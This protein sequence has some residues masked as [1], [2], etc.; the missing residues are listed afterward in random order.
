MPIVASGEI[1]LGGNATATRSVACEIQRSGTATIC[2][3]ESAV[4]ILAELPSGQISMSSFYGKSNAPTA[5]GAFFRGGYYTGV[6]YND[7]NAYHLIV[8]PN[9]TGCACCQWKTTYTLTGNCSNDTCNLNNGYWNTFTYLNNA[10]HPAGNWTATRS[11]GGFSDWYLPART[12]LN[13]LY[14]N[15]G[16]MPAGEGY[17]T[18]VISGGGYW[19]SSEGYPANC[20]SYYQGMGSGAFYSIL[21][22]LTS[23][24]RAVRR[25]CFTPSA[26]TAL[27]QF[28]FGGYYTGIITSP[29]NYYLIVAP[30]A[31]GCA[32]CAWKT[33]QTL[34]NNCSNATCNCNNGYWNTFTYLNN[35][36]HPAGNWTATRSI[37]GFSDWYLPARSELN[38]LYTNRGSMPAGEGFASHRYWSSSEGN[39]NG[40]YYQDFYNV[41]GGNFKVYP[42]RLRAVRRVS[43]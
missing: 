41:I 28:V 27:G 30:N 22:L 31:T 42:Y 8:A 3:N 24:L 15:Q 17:N 25:N 5:M 20:F 2:M 43:F 36:A 6:A 19:V 7:C 13:V 37:G 21:K 16:S 11:I 32:C 39:A 29:A 34:T 9:A 10:G 14:T 35:A 38:V 33:T 18:A 4:R 26:P 1:S 12:E 23:R 40:A